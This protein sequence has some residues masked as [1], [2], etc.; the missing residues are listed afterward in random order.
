MEME[1][2][3]SY[4][5]IQSIRFGDRVDVQIKSPDE[6]AMQIM[7]PRMVIQP[8]VENAYKHAFREM[9]A[10]GRLQISCAREQEA[11]VISVVDN[12]PGVPEERLQEIRASFL[13][14]EPQDHTDLF[15]VYQR[16]WLKYGRRDAL[17]LQNT[18]DGFLVRIFIPLEG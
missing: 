16:L 17:Q 15:N 14:E 4:L 11:L 8:L 2:A 10:G 6:G 3:K 7:V 13:R 5:E 12:G 1:F 9:E 18:K